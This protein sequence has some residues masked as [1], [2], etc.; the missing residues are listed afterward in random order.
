MLQVGVGHHV[1]AG[2]LSTDEFFI[3]SPLKIA[4]VTDLTSYVG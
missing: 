3:L 1:V 2:V 4:P